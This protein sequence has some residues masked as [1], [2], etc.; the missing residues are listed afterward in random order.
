MR[1]HSTGRCTL[2]NQLLDRL[3]RAG[4]LLLPPAVEEA[5]LHV[6][7]P[8]VWVLQQLI[9]HRVQDVLNAGVLDV[10]T[11]FTQMRK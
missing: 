9:H 7:E 2:V 10:V 8:S 11:I 3:L 4:A 6:D 1:T 5:R